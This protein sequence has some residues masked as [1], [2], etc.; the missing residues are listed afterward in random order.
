VF[1]LRTLVLSMIFPRRRQRIFISLRRVILTPS[2]PDRIEDP[3]FGNFPVPYLF[4]VLL[5]GLAALID[6]PRLVRPVAAGQRPPLCVRKGRRC[7]LRVSVRFL[8]FFFSAG[9]PPFHF[10]P[11]RSRCAFFFS[12]LMHARLHP[13]GGYRDSCSNEFLGPVFCHFPTPVSPCCLRHSASF[14]LRE[15]ISSPFSHEIM[16]FSP[17]SLPPPRRRQIIFPSP[18]LLPS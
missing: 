1:P 6:P 3:G 16:D 10:L 18:R 14:P 13:L 5:H 12:S 2:S 11:S 7:A 17:D 15:V 8:P 9:G 4:S